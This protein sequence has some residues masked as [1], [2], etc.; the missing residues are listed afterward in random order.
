MLVHGGRF[1]KKSER[2]QKFIAPIFLL[3]V[4][5]P[6]NSL[7]LLTFF[8][9]E[10]PAYPSR[11][12]MRGCVGAPTADARSAPPSDVA[13]HL[14]ADEASISHD[15]LQA[16]VRSLRAQDRGA[17]LVYRSG[18][19]CLIRRRDRRRRLGPRSGSPV[20]L[21]WRGECPH[22]RRPLFGENR[23]SPRLLTSPIT[24]NG[25]DGKTPHLAIACSRRAIARAA[26]PRS[27]PQSIRPSSSTSSRAGHLAG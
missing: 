22:P 18:P 13:P 9:S 26:V 3:L 16:N 2:L 24:V 1:H 10:L 27:C 17:A 12:P 15:A 6:N 5:Q 23:S 4:P 7:K 25:R 14:P 20:P 21:N 8:S 19:R 11:L